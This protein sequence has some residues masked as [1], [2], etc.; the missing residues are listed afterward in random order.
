MHIFQISK[1]IDI[2]ANF[3]RLLEKP[4]KHLFRINF[5]IGFYCL[6]F[7]SLGIK[8]ENFWRLIERFQK[9]FSYVILLCAPS[10]FDFTAERVLIPLPSSFLLPLPIE[11][12]RSLAR[13]K[14]ELA[15][16]WRVIEALETGRAWSD[17]SEKLASRQR[18][19]WITFLSATGFQRNWRGRAELRRIAKILFPPSLPLYP[20]KIF[21]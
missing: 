13:S 16:H 3:A 15:R 18:R 14:V 10:S 19:L 8:E 17:D 20:R 4:H 9:S 1:A 6:L 2:E 21:Q 5:W 7:K 12:G 11:L